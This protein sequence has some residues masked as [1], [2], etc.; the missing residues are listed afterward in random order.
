MIL[1]SLHEEPN[2][3]WVFHS[4]AK[5]IFKTPALS[6][7]EW[8]KWKNCILFFYDLSSKEMLIRPTPKFK[9]KSFLYFWFFEELWNS[10]FVIT[11]FIICISNSKKKKKKL[12]IAN[13]Y[14]KNRYLNLFFSKTTY[15]DVLPCSF[16][17]T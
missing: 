1:I 14:L 13:R 11:G 2:F 17:M 8:F 10:F 5:I 12:Y 9:E 7:G 6:A 16:K 15:L 4:L 3:W